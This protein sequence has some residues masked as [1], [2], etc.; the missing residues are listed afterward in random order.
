[1]RIQHYRL[2]VL[3]TH[4]VECLASHPAHHAAETGHLHKVLQ[5][6]D[7]VAV[8]LLRATVHPIGEYQQLGEGG[9]S[10]QFVHGLDG[11]GAVED[12]S[13]DLEVESRLGFFGLVVE[14]GGDDGGDFVK[15][16]PAGF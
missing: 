8:E 11:G 13:G 5:V 14:D 6:G 3:E 16:S 2:L 9:G 15:A 1:M 12:L 7:V 10:V 4:D